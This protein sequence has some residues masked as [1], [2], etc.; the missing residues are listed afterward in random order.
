MVRLNIMLIHLEQGDYQQALQLVTDE[1]KDNPDVKLVSAVSRLVLGQHEQALS[2]LEQLN[3]E[4]ADVFARFAS[5]LQQEQVQELLRREAADRPE[6]VEAI[7][8]S[9]QEPIQPTNEASPPK[10]TEVAEEHKGFWNSL[11]RALRK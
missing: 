10:A 8:E 5:L 3:S 2:M 4:H 6:L 11:L 1:I 7:L 9:S